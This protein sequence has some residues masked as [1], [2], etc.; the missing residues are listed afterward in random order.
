M[1]TI[2]K[3]ISTLA[4][5]LLVMISMRAGAQCSSSFVYSYFGNGVVSFTSTSSGVN[6]NTNYNW[7]F[8]NSTSSSG[9]GGA[10]MGAIATYTA[11]GTYTVT[12]QINNTSPACSSNTFAVITVT[13]A[14]CSLNANLAYTMG[15]NGL[16][17]FSDLSTGTAGSTTY[18]LDYGDGSPVGSNPNGSH[19]YAANGNYVATLTVD[20]NLGFSCTSTKT[21]NV[22]VNTIC[23]INASFN[24]FYN[25]P[26]LSGYLASTSTGTSSSSIYQWSI[27]SSSSTYS[28]SSVGT[29]YAGALPAGTYTVNLTVLGSSVVPTCSSTVSQVLVVTCPG[30]NAALTH[31]VMP[32]GVVNFDSAP[33]GTVAGYT[34][35]SNWNFGDGN[36]ASGNAVSNTYASAGVYTVTV[37]TA[38]TGTT[39]CVSSATQVVN[40]TG[41]PCVANANFTLTQT[42]T[43]LVWNAI[44]AYPYNVTAV[45]WSWGDGSTSNTLYT[46]H[47][48]A[49]SGTYSICLTVTTSCGSSS[50]VCS[51]Y[52]VFRSS[53]AQQNLS[54]IQVNVIPPA[55]TPTGINNNEL[56]LADFN[57]Y[58]NPA[59]G[60][61]KINFGG[62]I[63]GDVKVS[64]Y[65]VIGELVREIKIDN[66]VTENTINL[67][68]V[69][70]G[71]Y[72]LKTNSGNTIHAKKLTISK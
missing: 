58:P 16:I 45:Q 60:E 53:E 29:P 25:S 44:P 40:V 5:V 22:V 62:V 34:Y 23:N 68:G 20:N 18:T 4:I 10:F 28:W 24:Y 13:N 46:S 37:T 66:S 42:S 3:K 48:Y 30:F 14:G 11:N 70:S 31:T 19:T 52:F 6:S 21:L 65:N 26:G 64:L 47:N 39:G 50:A 43:P 38:E 15:S 61:V 56:Q 51:S 8:G 72:I 57:V 32:G 35:N 17:N 9:T 55:G 36:A 41:I 59:S 33:T 54:M 12:L 67:D 7:N 69:P 27:T 2:T 63:N 71:V 49:T 1:K